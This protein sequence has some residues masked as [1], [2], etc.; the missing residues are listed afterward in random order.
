MVSISIS[1]LTSLRAAI[2]T[3]IRNI[4][5]L[6]I[7]YGICYAVLPIAVS[8]FFNFYLANLCTI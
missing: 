8:L 4:V 5:L 3:T 1:A 7:N 2:L 6:A